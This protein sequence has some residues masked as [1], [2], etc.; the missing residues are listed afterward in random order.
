MV[1]PNGAGKT[2][3]LKALAGLTPT[4]SGKVLWPDGAQTHPRPVAYLPQIPSHDGEFPITVLEAVLLGGQRAGAF[5]ASLPPDSLARAKAALRQTGLEGLEERPLGALSGGELR[6]VLF[7]RTLMS[8]API[9]LLDEPLAGVDMK[10]GEDLVTLMT[11]YGKEGKI[12][13]AV[14]HDLDVARK[15][16]PQ[17]LLLSRGLVTQGPTAAVLTAKTLAQAWQLTPPVVEEPCDIPENP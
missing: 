6:R 7:A 3:F 16:F 15:Y 12:I 8:D 5:F 10:A 1:G 17:T 13:L 9:W 11:H 4:E 2:T 14:L